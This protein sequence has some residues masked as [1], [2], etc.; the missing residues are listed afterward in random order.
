MP[1]LMFFLY[2]RCELFLSFS[3]FQFRWVEISNSLSLVILLP[4]KSIQS[5]SWDPILS[6]P[7][8]VSEV[9]SLFF[10][11]KSPKVHFLSL[12]FLYLNERVSSEA[13]CV[14]PSLT[15]ILPAIFLFRRLWS[16]VVLSHPWDGPLDF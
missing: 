14:P 16:S 2:E 3:L 13:F 11:Q 10:S 6:L 1:T 8:K 9:F 4:P 15:M 7:K 12:L 5:S